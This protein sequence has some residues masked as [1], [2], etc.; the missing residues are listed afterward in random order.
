MLL[1]LLRLR[2]VGLFLKGYFECHAFATGVLCCR[3]VC[4]V[5]VGLFGVW[6]VG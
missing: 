6:C 1:P 5:E 3:L 4:V 2:G